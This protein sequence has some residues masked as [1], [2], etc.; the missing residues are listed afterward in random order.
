MR[1]DG[2]QHE[3]LK[4]SNC[5][6]N[7][8]AEDNPSIMKGKHIPILEPD[9]DKKECEDEHIIREEVTKKVVMR[10]MGG[11]TGGKEIERGFPPVAEEE[12]RRVEREG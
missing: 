4:Q 10:S 1:C 5:L 9:L 2:L 8:C 11:R 3:H 6:P 7:E 12:K